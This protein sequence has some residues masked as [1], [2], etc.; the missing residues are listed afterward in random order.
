[1]SPFNSAPDASSDDLADKPKKP[2]DKLSRRRNFLLDSFS[3]VAGAT[4]AATVGAAANKKLTE[5]SESS[6]IIDKARTLGQL[7]NFPDKEGIEGVKNG[8]IE[9]LQEQLDISRGEISR[10]RTDIEAGLKRLEK[11]REAEARLKGEPFSYTEFEKE[12][13]YYRVIPEAYSED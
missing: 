5:K 3:V 13:A 4:V 11:L 6:K 8:E 9:K 10:S 1:M 7:P 12:K 2:D